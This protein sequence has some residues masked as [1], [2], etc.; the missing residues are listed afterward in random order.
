MPDPSPY[1]IQRQQFLTQ[2]QGVCE[3]R[4]KRAALKRY[5]S[6]TT[7]HLAW[8]VLGGLGTIGRPSREI[9]AAL[10]A[11]HGMHQPGPNVGAAALT[12]GKMSAGAHPYDSQFRRLLASDSLH[13]LA[14]QLHRLTKRLERE[15]EPL[16]YGR[17][18]QD[19]ELWSKHSR[20]VKERWALAFW[21]ASQTEPNA[22]AP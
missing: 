17:L 13:D 22:D 15:G 21:Q 19:L 4:G 8:P 20:K 9:T 7:R 18:L 12:L 5:W 14:T 3:D 1:E 16:D 11:V 6:D 10:Y 2:L